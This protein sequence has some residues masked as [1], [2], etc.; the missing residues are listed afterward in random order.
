MGFWTTNVSETMNNSFKSSGVRKEIPPTSILEAINVYNKQV[1][2]LLTKLLVTTKFT[3][4]HQPYLTP[5]GAVAKID[6]S[7]DNSTTRCT[8]K[9]ISSTSLPN[10]VQTTISHPHIQN[11]I[12]SLLLS[13]SSE[14]HPLC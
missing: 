6:A 1:D 10:G 5:V 7:M 3:N 8:F 4:Y 2:N 11:H 14:K 12:P 9:V 13:G